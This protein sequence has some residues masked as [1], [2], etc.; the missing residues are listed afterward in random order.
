MCSA[1]KDVNS[2]S[3]FGK[4]NL[5]EERNAKRG[6]VLKKGYFKNAISNDGDLDLTTP[7]WLH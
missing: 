6:V 1:N 3:F 2:K 5:N 4:K 7:G